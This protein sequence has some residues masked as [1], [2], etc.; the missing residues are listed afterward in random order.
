MTER[1]LKRKLVGTV[2]SNR[3]DKTIVVLVERMTK[4]TTY[5]KYVRKRSK[6]MAHD[7][8]NSCEIGDKV[9]IIESRP[10][11]KLKRWQIVEILDKSYVD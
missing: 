10:F 6:H 2:V 9:K 7:P 4:H 8:R 1:G 3:M 11:S 5:G